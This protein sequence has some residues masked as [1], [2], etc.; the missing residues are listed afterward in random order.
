VEGGGDSRALLR[1]CQRAFRLFFERA[2]LPVGR[3]EVVASG[4]RKAAYEDYCL[5][6]VQGETALLLVDSE[7]PVKL[8]R[9]TE[10]PMDPWQHL[11]ERMGDQWARPE[12]AT[13]ADVHLMAPVM[14][15]WFVADAE[16]LARYYAGK[17]GREAFNATAIPR[18]PNVDQLTKAD[19]ETAL[20]NAT[21]PN[22]SKGLYHKG[23]HSFEILA[24]LD[25]VVV[26]R[27]SYQARRLL[28][29][30]KAVLQAAMGWLDCG[31]FAASAGGS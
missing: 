28:C 1:E 4:S 2:G 19:I 5:A 24:T 21:R 23:Q 25:P 7:D 17:F 16:A 3:F 11:A 31:E 22:K 13:A 20:L 10:L 18:R 27:G 6:L 29:H 26:A 9:R 8:D 12:G 14:E 30:L 15:A